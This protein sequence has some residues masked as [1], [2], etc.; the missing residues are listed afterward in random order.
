MRHYILAIVFG[1]SVVILPLKAHAAYKTEQ[2]Q[3]ELETVVSGLEHPWALAFLPNGEILVT[4]RPGRLNLIRGKQIFRINGLPE[5]A[6]GGQGGLLD[7]LVHPDFKNNKTIFFSYSAGGLAKGKNTN[8]ARAELRGLTLQN[9]K[10]I[11]E[12]SPKTR[13]SNHFGSR[14]AIAPDDMLFITL[15]ERFKKNEAQDPSNHLG[16]VVRIHQD[17]R[18][19]DDNPFIGK[20]GYAPEIYSYG[21]RN[22]QG[23]AVHP[24]TGDIWTHEHGP[25]GGDEVNILKTGANYGWPEITYGIGYS[26]LAISDKTKAEGMEQPLIYWDPSIAPSGMVFYTGDAFPEW[27]GDLFV[28]ALALTHLR[29]LE[30]KGNQIIAQEVLLKDRDERIRDVKNAPD[31]YLYMLTDSQEGSILRLVPTE[32]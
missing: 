14:L 22:V 23:I 17:G 18:I 5:I 28:G 13:G 25:R 29:R 31:G 7:V 20:D 10:V 27:Q 24:E 6:D 12:A 9:V 15:G 11:F 8:V 1:L 19:P 32:K 4:E 26:G 21:H 16:T 2:A 30:L 3:F